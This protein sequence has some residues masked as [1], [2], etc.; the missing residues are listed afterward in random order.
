MASAPG[1][2]HAGCNP[3]LVFRS[4]PPARARTNTRQRHPFRVPRRGLCR[5]GSS[6]AAR[7]AARALRA[8]I[9]EQESILGSWGPAGRGGPYARSS[10]RGAASG[11]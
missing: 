11:G 2:A 1:H 8:A 10:A 6:A 9:L 7:D 3:A 5:V 4:R